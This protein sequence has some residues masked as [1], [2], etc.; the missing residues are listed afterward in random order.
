MRPCLKEKN[1]QGL[2]IE[3][4]QSDACCARMSGF[5]SHHPGKKM[6]LMMSAHSRAGEAATAQWPDLVQG[7]T[8]RS[9]L[10]NN[11]VNTQC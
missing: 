10:K 8:E 5:N 11:G 7:F 9:S 3:Y 4:S 6:G 2:E 1:K